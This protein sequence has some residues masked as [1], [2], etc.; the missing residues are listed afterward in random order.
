MY[1]ARK[2]N[3]LISTFI[4]SALTPLILAYLCHQYLKD[5]RFEDLPFHSLLESLGTFAALMLAVIITMSCKH[6]RLDSQYLWVA[7]ALTGM[8]VM[9]GFHAPLHIGNTFVWLHSIATMFGGLLFLLIYLP[10]KFSNNKYCSHFPL[11][12]F[13]VSLLISSWSLLWPD[14]IPAMTDAG[15]FTMSAKTINFI[16]GGGFILAW[17]YFVKQYSISG[18][19]DK[20]LLAHHCLLFGVAGF[21]FKFSILWDATWWLWHVLRLIAYLVLLIYFIYLYNLD[22]KRYRILF[23]ENPTMLFSTNKNGKII[24]VNDF[25]AG[26]LG[27]RVDELINHPIYKTYKKEDRS[28]IKG[29]IK[30]CLAQPD[31]VHN[32]EIQKVKKGG[33]TIWVKETGR[34]VLDEN[35]NVSLFIVCENVT[36]KHLLSQ[37]L[38]YQATHDTLTGLINR[39]EFEARVEK[40]IER[41]KYEKSE[42]AVCFIDLDQF[43][44]INDT[45]GHTA[46]DELLRQLGSVFK[47]VIRQRDTISRLGGDEFGV[48]IEHCSLKH[49]HRVATTLLTV[50]NEYQFTWEDHVFKLGMSIGL[51]PI[52]ELTP[53]LNQ[54]LQDADTACYMA[55]NKGRNQIV[56]HE[57]DDAD[58]AILRGEIHWLE[59]INK[60]LAEDKLLIYAQEIVPLN[61]SDDKHYEVLVRMQD[62][63][64]NIILPGA[65]LIAAE[66]YNLTSR[67]DL[68]MLKNTVKLLK[69]HPKF[70]K[71]IEFIALNLSGHSLVDEKFL[72]NA[73]TEIHDSG[74]NGSKFC[75][76]ITETATISNLS[77]ADRFIASLKQYG[78]RFA[79]DD[80]GSGLSSFGY[81]KHLLVDYLK[82]DGMFVKDIVVDP[83][84]HAMVKSINEIGQV[85]GMKTIAEFVENDEIK[86]MLREIGVNYAQGYAMGKPRLLLDIIKEQENT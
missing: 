83:I 7:S 68:W 63:K 52:T 61:E 8:G 58:L 3:I 46:G 70:L 49:A 11:A 33:D 31:I 5:W 38:S 34:Y 2:N 72:N 73:M 55:K 6:R 47:S 1:K 15:K 21:I 65:F 32:W 22:I 26:E 50:I 86:G 29:H 42:Y 9:D 66:R 17:L 69:E 53:N 77:K 45:C 4:I 23:K 78:C 43:K 25:A 41:V 18:Q 16:G 71:Q 54:L 84:D 24:S 14:A 35:D 51:V 37:Q 20:L 80:F 75:F 44:I 28:I 48:L 27:Y 67:L 12:I 57:A 19:H 79:L 60:S 30:A 36:E 64:G 81:L 39:R 85:M 74:I 56:I 59:Q 76:E 82:I 62:D 10:R 40:V 13:F